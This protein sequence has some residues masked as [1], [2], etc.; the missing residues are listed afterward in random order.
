VIGAGSSG[1]AVA[2]ALHEHGVPFDCL[3]KSD[4]VGGNWV[5]A[6]P[7]GMS[8]AYRGLFI[9]TS[10]ERMAYSDFPMPRSF[11]DFPHHTHIRAYFN[12]YV[13]HFGF[14]DRIAFD[15][16]VARAE[17][18][19]GGGW[20]ITC[21]D[22]QVRR[23]DA[24]V[25]ANGHHWNPRWPEPAFP[26]ADRFGGTQTHAHSYVDNEVL[27]DRDVVVLGMGNSAMD[28][29]VESSYVARSTYLA[30]RRGAWVVPKYLGGRPADR[31]HPVFSNPRIPFKLR[32]AIIGTGHPV[33]GGRH[34]GLRAAQARSPLRRGPSHRLGAHPRP[35]RPR[36]RHPQAQHLRAHRGRGA[37][38][39]RKRGARRPRHLLHR[40]QD[41]L[42]LLRRGAD[43]GP[44]EPHR[45]L[46]PR[47]SP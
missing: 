30:A 27:R 39:R 22:G 40:L 29:A 11:P 17:R 32:Q 5:F 28:I 12:D 7:N 33:L 34:G 25:V 9:N 19:P 43:L 13:D 18:E 46:S 38:R 47:L 45:A 36:D 15:T 31:K 37:L 1:I 23:Y 24:L 4:Q 14:G 20:R 21:E 44:G 10:R 8:A 35:Y 41:H 6:N 2:K 26:G 16:G 3:E 42:P